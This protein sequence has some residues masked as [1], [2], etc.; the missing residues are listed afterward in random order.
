M[1]IRPDI[2]HLDSHM[3]PIYA[4]RKTPRV[5]IV[6]TAEYRHHVAQLAMQYALECA[7]QADNLQGE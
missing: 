2:N 7:Q 6:Q 3:R 5:D 1:I 4:Q